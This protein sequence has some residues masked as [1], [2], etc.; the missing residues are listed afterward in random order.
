MFRFRPLTQADAEAIAAWSYS[1]EY[2]FYDWSADADDERELLTPALRADAYAAV[3]DEAGELVGFFSFKQPQPGTVELGLGL[4]PDHTGRGLGTPFVEAGLA[5][6]RREYAPQRFTLA[7]ASFNQRAIA[8]Y[9]R[10]GFERSRTYLH[11]TNGSDWE[12]V[13]MQRPA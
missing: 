3:D 1:D 4:R 8:V 13:E 11:R 6:A 2:A 7:V 12:F 9:E 5:Y 10:A